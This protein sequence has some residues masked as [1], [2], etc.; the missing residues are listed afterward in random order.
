MWSN[1]FFCGAAVLFASM[2]TFCFAAE[3]SAAFKFGYPVPREVVPGEGTLTLPKELTV[4]APR[5]LAPAF[6]DLKELFSRYE[7]KSRLVGG[8]KAF[9]RIELSSERT[10]QHPQGYLLEVGAEHIS[11]TSRTPEGLFNG[12]QTLFTMLLEAAKPELPLCRITDWPEFSR[13]GVAFSVNRVPKRRMAVLKKQLSTLSALKYNR[14]VIEFGSNFPYMSKLFHGQREDFTAAEIAELLKFAEER[15]IEIVPMFRI[16]SS[17]PLVTDRSDAEKLL[18][19]P[20]GDRESPYCPS[21]PLL[22]E[23]LKTAIAEQCAMIHPRSFVF[24]FDRRKLRQGFRLCSECRKSPPERLVAG[25]LRM[26]EEACRASGTDA[27]FVF[28]NFSG[29]AFSPALVSGLDPRS[30]IAV[31]GTPRSG[32]PGAASAAGGNF[33]AA[34]AATAAAGGREFTVFGFDSSDDGRIVPLRRASPWFFGGVVDAA[35]ALWGT[36]GGRG[37]ADPVALFFRIYEHEPDRPTTAALPVPLGDVLNA[38]LNQFEGFPQYLDQKVL[39]EVRGH[40]AARPE[41]FLLETAAG[42]RYYGILLSSDSGDKLPA[43]PVTVRLGGVKSPVLALLLSCTQPLQQADFE[44]GGEGVYRYDEVAT[45]T[46]NYANGRNAMLPL[47]YMVNITDWNR[48]FGGY[49]LRLV[50]SGADAGGRLVN[51][52]ATK[53]KNP[54]P[55]W[56]LA[57][58]SFG[59]CRRAGIAPALLAL[60]LL[61]AEGGKLPEVSSEK[62]KSRLTGRI[63]WRSDMP[64]IVVM[65][66]ENSRLAPASLEIRNAEFKDGGRLETSFTSDSSSPSGNRVLRIT[67]PAAKAVG[68]KSIILSL[69]LPGAQRGAMR[70]LGVSCRIDRPEYLE[71]AFQELADTHGGGTYRQRI[72][73]GKNWETF[74]TALGNPDYDSRLKLRDPHRSNM[75]RIIFCFK[76]LPEPVTILIDD[77]AYSRWIR[78]TLPYRLA[79]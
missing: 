79:E 74:W 68:G 12:M 59:T 15:F 71:K 57:S 19:N 28:E 30:G 37:P 43:A 36:E 17:C 67:L 45:V 53:L 69:N 64:K 61:D 63:D 16:W 6:G 55:D 75:R 1:K 32:S 44:P 8:D 54:H 70:S 76:D 49:S 11:I 47:Y 27:E 38:E 78:H 21:K 52:W 58:L 20:R 9:L 3:T 33:S 4:S 10:P 72:R 40:L 56:P 25:H 39:E 46:L 22:S 7:L 42:C 5:E 73:P 77:I 2:L 62:T 60:S 14:A 34:A 51:W 65:D 35:A 18:E 48:Q 50:H 31:M 41:K 26:L 66:F 29:R 24:L 13:R 23:L